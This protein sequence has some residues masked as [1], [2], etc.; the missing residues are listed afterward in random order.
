MNISFFPASS[1]GKWSVWLSLGTLAAYLLLYL[2]GTQ[3]NLLPPVIV[4]LTLNAAQVGAFACAILAIIAVFRRDMAVLLLLPL[5][6]SLGT[7]YLVISVL[8]K[9]AV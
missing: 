1:P 6:V 9:G 3:L 5:L 7:L 8:V 4:I 2:P